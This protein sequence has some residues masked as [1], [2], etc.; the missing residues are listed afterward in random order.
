VVAGAQGTT[1]SISRQLLGEPN[2]TGVRGI[3]KLCRYGTAWLREGLEELFGT[4]YIN[5]MHILFGSPFHEL[6]S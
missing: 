1:M 6:H 4:T 5:K 3:L 2:H